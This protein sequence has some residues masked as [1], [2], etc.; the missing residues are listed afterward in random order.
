MR[1]RISRKNVTVLI[2]LGLA[3]GMFDGIP[4]IRENLS[5]VGMA[6]ALCANGI[7]G[8]GLGGISININAG[9]YVSYA[10]QAY[11]QY[12]YTK[13]GCA[14]FASA[15]VREL[16]GKGTAIYGGN[17]WYNSAGPSLGFARGSGLQA[18]AVACWSN[19]VA[20]VEAVSGNT[21]YISEGG[22]TASS[23][24]NGY[25]VIR[26][27]NRSYFTSGGCGTWL[28]FV[29]L[30]I[31]GTVTP[32]D[33][34]PH[35]CVDYIGC[36]EPGKVK[37]RGWAFDWDNVGVSLAVHVYIGGPA[38]SGAPG[39]A[40]TA[41]VYRPDVNRAYPGVGNYHGFE[42]V[43]ET[44]MAGNQNVF[45]YA[46]NIR[47]NGS[48]PGNSN[49]EFKGK[50]IYITTDTA[51]PTV[52]NIKISDVTRGYYTVTATA[53]DNIGVKEVNFATWT[54]KN[55]QDDLKWIKGVNVGN[56]RWQCRILASDH[57]MEGGEYITHVYA[58]DAT[59]NNQ[60][61]AAPAVRL[62]DVAENKK[63]TSRRKFETQM[64]NMATGYYLY[65]SE[66][67]I[68]D[69]KQCEL[70]NQE[71]N[72][73][74][75]EGIQR[76]TWIFSRQSDGCYTIQNKYSGKMIEISQGNKNPGTSV[77]LSD[78]KEEGKN[79]SQKFYMYKSTTG[80]FIT[81][82]CTPYTVLDVKNHKSG[83][84]IY[85]DYYDPLNADQIFLFNISDEKGNKN[86]AAG[87]SAG[88]VK[89]KKSSPKTKKAVA[90]GKV[91][92]LK[93]GNKKKKSVTLSWKK[94]SGV[95][96]Y[97]IQ[98]ATNKKFKKKKSKYIKSLSCT[99]KKLKKTKIYYF[100]IRAYRLN[101]KEKIYGKWSQCR[102]VRIKK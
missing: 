98:Y 29:Y 56:N 80:Y 37:V 93:A 46:I 84:S 9:Y 75:A 50:S 73:K 44:K 66:K 94:V 39:Y 52:S 69:D 87:S 42:E 5:G 14:W 21:I 16:T 3:F 51:K 26:T 70:V 81:S 6:K 10:N 60:G 30:G 57:N 24:A 40:I 92:K 7:Q 38:G 27:V 63:D 77:I 79:D 65:P 18:K 28:G 32:A 4:V 33:K 19:H 64:L 95:K 97:Q 54:S 55:G 1:K 35:G 2:C 43:I 36:T 58:S 91:T 11:G 41:N 31:G 85:T 34:V 101:G 47:S 68:T 61:K 78:Q 76:G 48:Q 13:S 99:V 20:I 23:A 25:T 59:G 102:R 49:L 72:G 100:R 45:I 96:G 83:T 53:T 12:A 74:N 82:K 22:Y 62:P 15:R 90:P 88:S 86:V 89:G 8:N 17:N 67:T 71:W